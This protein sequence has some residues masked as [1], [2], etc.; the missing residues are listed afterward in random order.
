MNTALQNPKLKAKFCS[1]KNCKAVNPQ[2]ITAFYKNKSTKDGLS[3]Q[4]RECHKIANNKW[5]KNNPEKN[6]AKARRLRREL[7]AKDPHKA[8][9][10]RRNQRLKAEYGITLEQYNIMFAKQNG[11]CSICGEHAST[12]SKGLVVDHNHTN[13]KVRDLLCGLCNKML[14]HCRENPQ[15]LDR[16]SEYLEKHS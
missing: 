2:P 3:N 13:G 16:A 8:W 5:S 9:A 14:G 12:H 10:I 7:K 11:C 4:C 1:S 6:A 15:I